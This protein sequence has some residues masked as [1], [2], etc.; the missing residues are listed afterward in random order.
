[1]SNPL[2]KGSTVEVSFGHGNKMVSATGL[3]KEVSGD[4]IVLDIDGC[5]KDMTLEPGTD[6]YLMKGG[7]LHNVLESKQFP[8][9]TIEKVYE[10]LHARVNDILSIR[11]RTV[12][13]DE[14]GPDDPQSK[15]ILEDVFG[16]VQGVPEVENVTPAMLYRLIYQLHLKIDR[17]MDATELKGDSLFQVTPL[18]QV[19]I[20][21]AGVRLN[22]SEKLEEGTIIALRLD[23]PLE[24]CT[25]LQALG[26]VMKVETAEQKDKYRTSVKFIDLSEE[27]EEVI[28]RYVFKRQRELLRGEYG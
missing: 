25:R 4:R 24:T 7:G 23:L 21:A 2:E 26:E 19:N 12:N 16:E 11:Y 17:L 14:Y 3:I 13:P 9:I 18:E 6:I 28:T 5:D 22:L 8:R 1:M 10:R 27:T 15:I 20:S